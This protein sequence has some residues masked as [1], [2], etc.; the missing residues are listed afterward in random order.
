[1]K[2]NYATSLN[3]QDPNLDD[4]LKDEYSNQDESTYEEVEYDYIE[5]DDRNI[6]EYDSYENEYDYKNDDEI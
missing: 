4:A 6:V 1:M 2:N 5:Y 3:N